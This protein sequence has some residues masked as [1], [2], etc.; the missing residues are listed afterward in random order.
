VP[1]PFPAQAH[2]LAGFIGLAM[3]IITGVTGLGTKVVVEETGG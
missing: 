2:L 3:F 1:P